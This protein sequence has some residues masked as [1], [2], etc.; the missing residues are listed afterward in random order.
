MKKSTL[1]L[2]FLIAFGLLAHA[3]DCTS[4]WAYYRTITVDNSA[5][6][7]LT[8]YQV[9]FSLNTSQ[10]VTDGK[11]QADGAD[12]RVF[13]ADCTPLPFWGDSLGTS[14]DTRIW[15][16]V[17]GIA[18]GATVELQV[19]YGN[20]AAESATDGDNTFIFFDDFE[21]TEVDANKWEAVGEF[22]TFQVNDGFLQYASTAMNPG[23]RFKFA[24]TKASFE[25]QVVFDFVVERTNADGFGF[26]SSDT[27]APL[28]RFI[29]RDAG[30]GF[31]TLNQIAV[32]TDTTNN[33]SA[34]QNSYPILR[35]DRFAFNTV[36]I[37]PQITENDMFMM[38]RFANEGLGDENLDTL[39]VNNLVMPGFHFIISSFSPSFIIEMDNIRVRQHSDQPPSSAVGAEQNADPNQ[40][41]DLIDP[42]LVQ[43]FPNPAETFVNVRVDLNEDIQIQVSDAQGRMIPNLSTPYLSNNEQTLDLSQLP[44]G[45]YFMQL[46]RRSDGA[47]LHSHRLSIIR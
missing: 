36:S 46:I 22:A 40:V 23:P 4:G 43:V 34:S 30:F 2:T 14:T 25:E 33:G 3:Q 41:D 39:T 38:T 27:D 16:K 7:D 9:G 45:I 47:L 12:L 29:V 35:F 15:A 19:Y 44:S 21:G 26:S 37:T 18:A 20:P 6:G 24:R 10:L 13:T 5:G 11:L 17:P 32:I 8:D 28:N 1:F 31:D 42:S